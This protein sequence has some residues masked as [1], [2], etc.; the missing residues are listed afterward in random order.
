MT[1]TLSRDGIGSMDNLAALQF[2][3]SLPTYEPN[4]P[5]L[6]P[7]FNERPEIERF[8]L[9]V[10]SVDQETLRVLRQGDPS[11]QRQIRLLSIAQT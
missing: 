7:R 4:G 8:L 10:R 5:T 6:F 1:I 3:R 9:E 2:V 11:G